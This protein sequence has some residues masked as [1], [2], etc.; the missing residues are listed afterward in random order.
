MLDSEG[1]ERDNSVDCGQGAWEHLHFPRRKS[2]E[3]CV[4]CLCALLFGLVFQ[5]VTLLVWC[6]VLHVDYR[7]GFFF[8]R[9]LPTSCPLREAS[10]SRFSWWPLCP[11]DM[12]CNSRISAVIVCSVTERDN[13]T[14]FGVHVSVS[15]PQLCHWLAGAP[16][17]PLCLTGITF[18]R[19]RRGHVRMK[20]NLR[21]EWGN[22]IRCLS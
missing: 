3:A 17:P 21:M 2:L 9:V 16:C 6:G 20:F 14:G 18:L 11:P 12:S 7:R 5:H 8:P 4:S 19:W 13:T 15:E 10:E 1:G 22:V